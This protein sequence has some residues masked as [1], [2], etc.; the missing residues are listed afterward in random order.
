MGLEKMTITAYEDSKFKKKVSSVPLN[1]MQVFINP[2]KYTHSYNIDYKNRQAQGSNGPS[3]IFNKYM[4]DTVNFELVF[5]GTGVVPN[6]IPGT[7]PQSG[8]TVE[9]QIGNLRSLVF[10]FNG[11]I[12]RP[13]FLALTWGTLLFKCVLKTLNLNYTLFMPDGKPLRARATAHFLGFNDEVELA[14]QAQKTSPDLTHIR[15]V[16]AGDTLPLMCFDIYGS[17]LYYTQVAEFNH[18]NDF[19]NLVP[20]TQ[21]VFPPLGDAVS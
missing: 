6:A 20:G 21:L 17:S 7:P 12:H 9:K 5:D 1:P 10:T 18:L 3:P 8:D 19:R 4:S 15:M 2:D 13:N 16:K 14:L 11:N